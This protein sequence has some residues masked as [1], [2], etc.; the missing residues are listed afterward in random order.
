[1][2]EEQTQKRGIALQN[3]ALKRLKRTR[4]VSQATAGLA[5]FNLFI[6]SGLI[7]LAPCVISISR[8]TNVAA[9]LLIVFT[10]KMLQN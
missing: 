2:C 6:L 1:L 9:F 3:N 10:Q 8:H 5:L 7:L 4:A